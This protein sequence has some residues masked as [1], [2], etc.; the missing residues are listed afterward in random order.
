MLQQTGVS[1]SVGLDHCMGARI[2]GGEETETSQQKWA[3]GMT[4]HKG[5]SEQ[6]KD[7]ELRDERK[8][9]TGMSQEKKQKYIDEKGECW[10]PDLLHS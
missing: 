9:W 10:Q 7:Q 6:Y 8:G 2:C 1:Y 5:R 4:Q 3:R